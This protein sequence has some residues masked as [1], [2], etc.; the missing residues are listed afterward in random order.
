M[1]AF[2]GNVSLRDFWYADREEWGSKHVKDFSTK[3][4]HEKLMKRGKSAFL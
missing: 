3:R 1:A 4:K 2:N